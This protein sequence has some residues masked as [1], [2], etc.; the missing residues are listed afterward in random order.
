MEMTEPIRVAAQADVVRLAALITVFRDH[1]GQQLPATADLVRSL[2]Q[3]LPDSSVEFLV[4]GCQSNSL[5]AYSQTRY[6]YSVWSTGVEAE[7]ED[8]FVH[9]RQDGRGW[10]PG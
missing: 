4:A 8:L 5:W 3:L 10:G 6:S 2:E 1:L 7:L 9:P